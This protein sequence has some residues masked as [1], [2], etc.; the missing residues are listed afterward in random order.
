M[1]RLTKAN[2]VGIKLKLAMNQLEDLGSAN[3][4][5]Q[6]LKIQGVSGETYDPVG[7]PVALW[8]KDQIGLG[9]ACVTKKYIDITLPRNMTVCVKTPK[10]VRTFIHNFDRKKYPNLI[11]KES[12]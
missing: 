1:K 9:E 4:I 7:C 2:L 3:A 11:K 8:L 10:V 12:S 5:A 6:W